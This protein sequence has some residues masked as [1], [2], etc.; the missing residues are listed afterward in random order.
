MVAGAPPACRP[1]PPEQPRQSSRQIVECGPPR[2]PRRRTRSASRAISGP[3]PGRQLLISRL[4]I[5]ER[6]GSG[7]ALVRRAGGRSRGRSPWSGELRVAVLARDD[8]PLQ[9]PAAARSIIRSRAAVIPPIRPHHAWSAIVPHSAP[10]AKARR[11]HQRHPPQRTWARRSF[12]RS[13]V[14]TG[15][16][17]LVDRCDI[18]ARVRSRHQSSRPCP[19][20]TTAMYSNRRRRRDRRT[21]SSSG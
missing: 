9:H 15:C 10:T 20:A 19:A 12:D 14:P 17:V 11:S 8:H 13:S 21:S 3:H 7:R 1:I 2:G 18:S 6:A 16:R 4:D 5:V